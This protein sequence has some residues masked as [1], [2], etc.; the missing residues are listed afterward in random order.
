MLEGDL[1]YTGG[2]PQANQGLA[3][4]TKADQPAVLPDITLQDVEDLL[5]DG[6]YFNFS[7]TF[8]LSL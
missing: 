3:I 1:M 4:V 2:V 7:K 6:E 5:Q 8:I